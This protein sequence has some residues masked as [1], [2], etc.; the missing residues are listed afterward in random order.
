MSKARKLPSGSWN[1]QVYDGKDETGKRL[2][3]SFTADTKAEAEFL[4]AEYRTGRKKKKTPPAELSVGE[5]I[6]R[7][8]ELSREALS[9]ATIR[10][11]EIIRSHAFPDLMPVLVSRLSS[12]RLQEAVNAEVNRPGTQYGQKLS[13]KTI[14]SEWQL[15]STSLRRVCGLTFEVKLPKYQR[16]VKEYPDPAAVVAAIKGSDV[17]L[18]CLL[19]LW[20]SFTMSEVRGL[21]CSAVH[22]G[23][24]FIR[25]TAVRGPEGWTIKPTGK[26]S[27]RLRKH[28]LPA[29][30]LSLIN[31]TTTYQ[32]YAQN[33]A[34]GLLVPFSA[35]YI[36][37]HWKKISDAHGF[38]LS[39]HDLRHLNASIMLMLGVPEKYALER[40]GW[41]TPSV[42]K[43][44]YQHTF[45]SERERV[46]ARI[47][48]YF[49]AIISPDVE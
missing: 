16:R 36:Y 43:S 11:Y 5:V 41:S 21:S 2:W 47:N 15:L 30:L 12:E 40:G 8:I 35:N 3:V 6:D 46:D 17:E 14:Q 33:G 38:G 18:P 4:A 49:D 32:N 7:Y 9:P 45:T 25:Q 39:F 42:M 28:V 19:A 31:N 37:K 13:A 27:T 44:V 24:I 20:L 1:V 22:D 26:A 34:D 10:G 29:Y 23:C 48:D